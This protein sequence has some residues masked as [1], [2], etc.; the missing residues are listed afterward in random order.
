MDAPLEA[1]AYLSMFLGCEILSRGWE[2][3]ESF[4]ERDDVDPSQKVVMVIV[5]RSPSG[6]R[7]APPDLGSSKLA[8]T[9][10]LI[11]CEDMLSEGLA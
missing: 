1:G 7:R 4:Q 9:D 8:L 10:Q 5:G 6:V 2:V 3:T 11:P